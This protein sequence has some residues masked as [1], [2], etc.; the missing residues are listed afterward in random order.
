MRAKAT[1]NLGKEKIATYEEPTP[2]LAF[3]A[4][5]AHAETHWLGIAPRIES[6]ETLRIEVDWPYR[7]S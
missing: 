6:E 5:V 7:P 2:L 4:A 3:R 1:I